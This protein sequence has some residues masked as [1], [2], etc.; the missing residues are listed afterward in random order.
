MSAA[1][2]DPFDYR[3]CNQ[4]QRL[5]DTG[6]KDMSDYCYIARDKTPG[7]YAICADRPEW[8]KETA[9][10]VARW[11]EDGATVERL[12]RALAIA[13]LEKWERPPKTLDILAAE[14]T[15]AKVSTVDAGHMEEV[16][17]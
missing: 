2:H 1:K 13:E 7:A 5:T 12:P 17:L 6:A 8:S 4:A 16:A 9:A 10:T 15:A 3:Y 11:I 14:S